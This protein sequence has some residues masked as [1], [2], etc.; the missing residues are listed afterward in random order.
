MKGGNGGTVLILAGV[1]LQQ[2]LVVAVA[3]EVGTRV[4]MQSAGT[5]ATTKPGK[6]DGERSPELAGDRHPLYRLCRSD[7]I[8]VSFTFSPEFNQTTRVQPDGFVALR[9]IAPLYA[10]GK[11]LPEIDEAM[12]GAYSGFLHDPDITVTLKEFDAPHFVAT[13]EV[14]HPGKYELHG[15]TTVAEAVAIA[16][17]FT[18]QS[19][20]SQVV[21]FRRT[22]D[23]RV[24][25]RRL[26]VKQMLNSRN[27]NED[28][29]LEPGDLIFV[30]QS[31]LSKIRPYLRMPYLGV[32]WNPAQF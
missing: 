31:T 14:T 20:D 17:G 28:V 10:E 16:G 25:A 11:T 19:K 21:L 32:Y 7:L 9:G 23:D 2:V 8:E 6:A 4:A 5:S 13:G 26:D 27:L 24:E 30:P 1:L 22:A 12:R 3:Q 18:S 29:H 15:D